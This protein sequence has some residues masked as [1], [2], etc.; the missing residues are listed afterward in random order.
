ML[1]LLGFATNAGKVITGISLCE[2][3]VKQ[4]KAKLI[5]LTRETEKGTLELFSQYN[6]PTVFVSDK[7]TLG[8]Y[9]GKGFRSAAIVTDK[10]FADA[11][12]K[13]SEE[14]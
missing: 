13:E 2:K 9:T 10:G 3:A 5:I 11:I 1:R 7:E 4:K 8:K 6:I 12:L 14:V